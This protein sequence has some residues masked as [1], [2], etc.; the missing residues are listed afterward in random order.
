MKELITK[1]EQAMQLQILTT[2]I[3]EHHQQAEFHAKFAM[4]HA[5]ACQLP[6]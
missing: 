5:F 6:K 3:N 1:N 2:E 4:R